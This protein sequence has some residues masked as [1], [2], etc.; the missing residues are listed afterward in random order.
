MS[1]MAVLGAMPLRHA[2]PCLC[3]YWLV[4][5]FCTAGRIIH[6]AAAAL[7][8]TLK[9]EVFAFRRFPDLTEV[10]RAFDQ[11]REVYHFERPHEA[12][13]QEVPASRYQP[14]PRSMPEQLPE[15]EYDAGEIVRIVPTTKHYI[16]FKGRLWIVPRAFCGERV[17]IRSLNTDGQYGIFFG[18]YQIASID[19]TKPECVGHVLGQVSAMSPG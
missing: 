4:V 5:G 12:L 18:A 14:S 19:L 2:G 8:R 7:H 6:R 3:G 1:T 11:W 13:D 16:R 9:D 10:Q 15:A 17:A